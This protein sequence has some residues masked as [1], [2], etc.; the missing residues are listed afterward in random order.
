MSIFQIKF[1]GEFNGTMKLKIQH[2]LHQPSPAF[3]ALLE[4]E[5]AALS[6]HLRIDEARVLVERLPDASPPFRMSAH[7]VTPGPD[8]FAE[9]SDH[10]LRAALHKLIGGIGDKITERTERRSRKLLSRQ[11]GRNL[12]P[13]PSA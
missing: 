10:T 1:P 9:A 4:R 13:P 7:L 2:R 12:P 3:T 11:S 5:F 6:V 8:V